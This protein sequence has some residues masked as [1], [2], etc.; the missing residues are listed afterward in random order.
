MSVEVID[1]L[2]RKGLLRKDGTVDLYP[3]YRDPPPMPWWVPAFW[4][5]LFGVPIAMEI[6]VPLPW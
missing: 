3:G 5:V 4:L 2:G 1:H 6:W